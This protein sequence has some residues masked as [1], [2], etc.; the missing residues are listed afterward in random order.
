MN[1]DTQKLFM[2]KKR[3]LTKHGY[4]NKNCLWYFRILS[5]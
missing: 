3:F 4:G 5:T 2:G 1:C